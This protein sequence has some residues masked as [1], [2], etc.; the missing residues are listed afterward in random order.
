MQS[1]GSAGETS[2]STGGAA[3]VSEQSFPLS[4]VKVKSSRH[5][6]GG[7]EESVCDTANGMEKTTSSL[8]NS[9]SRSTFS[10]FS[11]SDDPSN[12]TSSTEDPVV[13][14]SAA[15]Q[16]HQR[17]QASQRAF[18]GSADSS[19]EAKQ[20]HIRNASESLHH[21]VQWHNAQLIKDKGFGWCLHQH[22]DDITGASVTLN[23]TDAR[24]SS[25]QHHPTK[26]THF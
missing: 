9:V 20:N 2:A 16:H 19:S 7:E 4:V 3:V 10:S 22:N 13:D 14:G 6:G 1:S 11:R 26:D 18:S 15:E 8:S 21:N 17:K 12:N 25:L 23:N 24:V 5:L